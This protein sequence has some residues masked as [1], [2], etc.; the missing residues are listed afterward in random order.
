[1]TT[2]LHL[3]CVDYLVRLHSLSQWWFSRLHVFPVYITHDMVTFIA[4]HC[5]HYAF[6]SPHHTLHALYEPTPRTH[7]T[8]HT[9]AT[10]LIYGW[11]RCLSFTLLGGGLST[12]AGNLFLSACHTSLMFVGRLIFISLPHHPSRHTHDRA[13][14]LP[15]ISPCSVTTLPVFPFCRYTSLGGGGPPPSHT[16]TCSSLT[17]MEVVAHDW[18]CT[19]HGGG[20]LLL[21]TAH[22]TVSP[23]TPPLM[24]FYTLHGI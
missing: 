20:R 7:H 19:H 4:V 15:S 9:V 22:H 13:F 14:S 21:N 12:P 8:H 11:S 5:R 10:T 23:H 18:A 17:L 1:M 3:S 2:V 16:H 6:S 24:T